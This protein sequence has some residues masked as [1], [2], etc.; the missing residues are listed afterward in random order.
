MVNDLPSFLEILIFELVLE[1]IKHCS[2]IQSFDGVVSDTTAAE[3]VITVDERIPIVHCFTVWKICETLDL[4][5]KFVPLPG[6]TV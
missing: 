4:K 6:T 3:H 1:L 5:A 2:P